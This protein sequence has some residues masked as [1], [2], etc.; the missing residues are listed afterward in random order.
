MTDGRLSASGIQQ[1][2]GG[3]SNERPART[4]WTASGTDDT[5]LVAHPAHNCGE[6]EQP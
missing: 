2:N 5:T 1:T 4:P 3:E 6:R